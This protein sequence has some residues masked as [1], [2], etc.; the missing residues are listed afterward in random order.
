MLVPSS[1]VPVSTEKKMM[2]VVVWARLASV[3][4]TAS[5]FCLGACLQ[6]INILEHS[7]R[8]QP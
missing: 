8:E 7:D 4:Q 6:R 1:C 3:L 2:S 5:S